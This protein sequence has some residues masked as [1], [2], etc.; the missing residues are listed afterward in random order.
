VVLEPVAEMRSQRAKWIM[1]GQIKVEHAEREQRANLEL[2]AEAFRARAFI[3]MAD[4]VLGH[5]P[6]PGPGTG[7]R[8]GEVNTH[9][10]TAAGKLHALVEAGNL[11]V[12]L[13]EGLE[14]VARSDFG[15]RLAARFAVHPRY[16]PAMG[17][18]HAIAYEP[19]QPVRYL[20]LATAGRAAG[21]RPWSKRR[22]CTRR[23]LRAWPLRV[24]GQLARPAAGCPIAYRVRRIVATGPM[25]GRRNPAPEG[26]GHAAGDKAGRASWRRT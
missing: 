9:V 12:E 11:P 18:Q 1:V 13:D 8:D 23:N 24:P 20:T 4:E 14:S 5:I 17:V 6:I 15:G 19:G 26:D 21:A 22:A 3:V 10:T 25:S 2:D 16:D 7:R